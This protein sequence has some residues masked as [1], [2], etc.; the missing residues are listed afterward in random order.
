MQCLGR[1]RFRLWSMVRVGIGTAYKDGFQFR[2]WRNWRRARFRRPLW[3]MTFRDD[4]GQKIAAL[5]LARLISTLLWRRLDMVFRMTVPARVIEMRTQMRWC[6]PARGWVELN[7][8]AAVQ[9]ANG[10]ASIKEVSK[11]HIGIHIVGELSMYPHEDDDITLREF[12]KRHGR[13]Y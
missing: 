9:S 5:R 12:S 2:F 13:S 11:D 1:F 6:G 3:G 4:G 10:S 8:D 7:V